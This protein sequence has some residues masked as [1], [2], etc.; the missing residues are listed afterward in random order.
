MEALNLKDNTIGDYHRNLMSYY[1]QV[2]TE[3]DKM[4][5]DVKLL[6][7]FDVPN[8]DLDSLNVQ[9]RTILRD[10]DWGSKAD[11]R[12][13]MMSHGYNKSN[14]KLEMVE[15][16][17]LPT[18]LLDVC[19]TFDMQLPNFTMN[20]QSPGSVVPAHEDTWYKWCDRYPNEME[21]HTF[22]DTKFYIW[23]LSDRDVGH[24]FQ[25]GHTDINWKRGDLIEM[26]FYARHATSNAGYTDKLLIQCLGIKQ[27]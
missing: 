11:W 26:P 5:N 24:A 13:Y 25:C 6:G 15:M 10:R 12:D 7:N 21:Q 17:D 16:Q 27:H 3:Q 1:E 8:F 2:K 23:F 14:T 20:I 9:D 18:A 4:H 22:Y 19:N